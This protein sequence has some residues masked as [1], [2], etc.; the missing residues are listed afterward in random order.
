MSEQNTSMQVPEHIA[1]RIQQRQ[2]EGT[3]KSSVMSAIVQSEGPSFPRISTR[4]SRF[5]LVEEG[6]ETV[7][8]I[9]LDVAIV[10]ANP[11]VSKSFYG[12]PYDPNATD[13][14]PDCFSHDGVRPDPSVENP[15]HDNCASC[16][17]NVL[18]SKITPSGAKSKLCADQRHLAVVPAAD[19]SGKVY[20]L[21]VPV[22]GM[23]ALREYFKHL[24]NYGVMPE[25]VV[26][27]LGFD[28][29]ATFPKLTFKYKGFLPNKALPRIEALSESDEV[30]VAVRML[31]PSAAPALQKPETTESAP[32]PKPQSEPE[33][34]PEPVSDPEAEAYE[35]EEA[36]PAAAASGVKPKAKKKDAEEPAQEVS[37][38]EQALDNMFDE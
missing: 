7:V 33:A 32:E 17:N 23:K 29:T 22:S 19:P 21:T 10:G 20:G 27:Q 15:V 28:D 6:V 8:G 14:R 9:N 18:G 24:N 13:L 30:K 1:K 31:P 5:R 38:L 16:P 25:E 34:K 2:Q 35:E 37:N 11:K 36:K 26:T 12:R 4:A 3:Q